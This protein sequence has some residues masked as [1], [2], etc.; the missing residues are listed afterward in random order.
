[1]RAL[2][3]AA[4]LGYFAFALLLLALRY[5]ILPQIESYRGDVE[6]MISTA[7]NRPVGIRRIEA[8][9]AGLR[10]A[11]HLEGFEIRDTRGQAALGFDQVEAEL[12]WSSLWRFQLRLAR[13]ELDS[14]TLLLRRDGKGRF[15]AAGLEI[16]PQ[17][18]DQDDFADWLLA[19]DR[20]VIRNASIAWQDEL[21]NAPLLEL[22]HLNFQL[23]NSG[24]RHRFGFTAEPPRQLAARIDIRGD[25]KGPDLDQLEA[26]KGDVYAELDYADL[27]G[28][29][30]WVDYPVSLPQGSGALRLWLGF[31][32]K[33]LVSATADVR[34]AD[35]RLQLRPD[36]PELNL[37]QLEGRLAG[38]RLDGGFE[39][40]LKHLT[41]ATRDGLTLQPT[42]LKLA[43]Q[44]AAANR[45]PQ[46]AASA[47]GLDLAALA[48]LAAYLPLDDANRARLV[49]HAP[50]GRVFDLKLD[51]KGSFDTAGNAGR[52]GKWSIKSRFEGL[53]LTALGPVPG[54]SGVSGRI[55]GSEKGGSVRLDGQRA[56]FELPTV[57][58]EPRLE[59]EA[60]SAD[61][62]W[63]SV[64]DGFQVLLN[65]AAFHNK[66][67]AGEASGNWRALG[68]GPGAIEL[69]A[70]LTRGSG[71]AVWRYMPLAVGKDVRDWLRVAII[72]GK[73]SDTTLKLRGDLRQFPFRDGKGGLFEVR[74]KFRDA[75]LR[76]AGSWPEIN[77]IEGDLLFSGQRMLITGKSGKI[78]GV[79]L[80]EVRA[81]IADLEQMEELLT[82]TGKA[83][84]P[85]ADFLRFI[86]ASPVGERIDHFT[87]D[88]KAEGNGE[89]DL[90][91]DLPLRR[92]GNSKVDGSYRFDGNRLTVDND[93]PPL[94][95]VRG[96]LRFT[97]DHL[98][99]R[100]I[101]GTLLGTP[102][103]VDVKTT[104]DGGVQVN[105]AGEV[106]MATLRRQFPQA[107]FD[108]LSGSTKWTGSV[109]V[110]KKSAE[111]KLGSNLVGLSSS[112]PEPFNKSATDTL[113][114]SFERKPPPDAATRTATKVGA[115]DT[116][117]K[118]A[119][120]QDM[121]DL[122]LGRALRMQLVRRHDASPPAITRGVLAIGDVSAAMPERSVMIAANLPRIN[123]DFWR[124]ILA[125]ARGGNG[126][127]ESA[128]PLLPAVQFDL[129]TPDL[130][131]QDKSFHDVRVSG[132]RPEGSSSTRFELKSRELAGN[133][134]WNS[135]GN[136]KLS[137]RIAQFS[138]PESV[139]SPAALQAK[140][141]EVIERI[142]ALDITVDKLSFK[143]RALGAVRIAAEN[144]DG[145]W[146]TRIDVK[147]EDGTLEAT[148]RWR[149][150]PTQPDTRVEFKLDA[151]SI[152]KL[153]ARIGYPDTVRRGNAKLSGNLS[154]TG[155][156]FT[157]DYP[158]LN[159]GLK[160]DA[161]GGQFIKL[162]PGVGRLLGILSLQ[163]LPRRI[164][165]DF[166][167]I[168][169]EGFA[170]DNIGGQ[171]A[172]ARG[173]METKELQIQGPSAKV[174]MSGTVNL[175]AETQDLKV[176]VQP[177]V[178][179]S[180]A[181]GAMI[182]N[183]VAGA[184]V[185]AAQKILRDPL[186]Q[187]FA[188][189]Y[190]VTGSWA[191]PKVEKLGQTQPKAVEG[192][193]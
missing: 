156:P 5:A 68:E 30:S 58:P 65:K 79:G 21:R 99:A 102:L 9:W 88:M 138:I 2:L 192:T 129:R 187:A 48:R 41:L 128:L 75:S 190:A 95:E 108:H 51:W 110:K 170:F 1:M 45:P 152:E 11:L 67:A 137:G 94:A 49:R 27:A 182:A 125:G 133:F 50:R 15:F 126:Q 183:P 29:R 46:G 116:A 18:N 82:V 3:W 161:S 184:V 100:G 80:R 175:G 172:I 89:L 140:T 159:G 74:G 63:Q 96:A 81:E 180:I 52:S 168:F 32:R 55:E 122:S 98:E 60:F 57:F 64:A 135:I 130:T 191:D 4:T 176:R 78:F 76:Y 113:A 26:W 146:N 173:V 177:A 22:K 20:V 142:P 115:R 83:L 169:S 39:A 16:T 43:W 54:I 162:E 148:G 24:S 107:V 120:A 193:K 150:S 144:R 42:D 40:E 37:L 72:G 106:N 124:G 154:W 104:G 185:W 127:T 117:T 61:L 111:V 44:D 73:A 112:L 53:G 23:D 143:D 7:I 188:F 114:F 62:D 59:L 145:Y 28:W 136:G 25:F 181:V 165:L 164:T 10:P 166:R 13:L 90:R 31:A 139:A 66:D 36:L 92:L 171:F 19:Q 167:D 33:E 56:S 179:E 147:N 38:R 158:S 178:G 189:E 91:L 151:T 118:P 87:E 14:P 109:R 141:S 97:A 6:Q 47:N 186:D 17:P 12:A 34:L 157:L 134:E 155:S 8:H 119:V 71:D 85:T 131:V 101:R 132:S 160:L 121:L 123:A 163:S 174:L 93:L 105:A 153:L 86:E 69:D 70:R 35:V 84:G 103:G 149:P 77:G